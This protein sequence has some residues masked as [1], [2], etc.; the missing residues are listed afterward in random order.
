M[1]KTAGRLTWGQHFA[2][3]LSQAVSTSDNGGVG[4]VYT[5]PVTDDEIAQYMP[6]RCNGRP[7]GEYAIDRQSDKVTILSRSG[8][9]RVELG[10]VRDESDAE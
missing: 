8:R 6:K 2:R 7:I 9:W 1:T 10:V 5:R 4:V 3:R